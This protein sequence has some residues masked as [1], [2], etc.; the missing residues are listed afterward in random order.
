MDAKI[1]LQ[2]GQCFTE[3]ERA[4][5]ME[6]LQAFHDEA[7][8]VVRFT[9][10]STGAPAVVLGRVVEHKEN[11]FKTA[12]MALLLTDHDE[13]FMRYSAVGGSKEGEN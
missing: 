13:F 2:D 6:L 11:S 4:A 8:C 5:L 9:N 1:Q 3:L 10:E 7:L 12:I